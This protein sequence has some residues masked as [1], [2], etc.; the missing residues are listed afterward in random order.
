MDSYWLAMLEGRVRY[1][2]VDGIS[3]RL[4]EAGDPS[5][6]QA[7]VCLHGSGG[8]AEN[9][10]TNVVPLSEAGYVLAPDLLGHGLS[11][12][13][14]DREYTF[15]NLI[16]Q[17][18]NLIATL[19]QEDV[20]LVGLSIGGLVAARVAAENPDRVKKLM[21]ICSAGIVPTGASENTLP[22]M[23]A[24]ARR[25]TL[26]DATE[27]SV[28]DRFGRIMHTT[29]ALS[30][31]MVA[32]RLWMNRKPG[33]ADTVVPVLVDYDENR[34]KYDA[35]ECLLKSIQA[36]TLFAWGG[37]NQPG[38]DVAEKAAAIMPAASVVVFENSKH[39]PHVE[40]HEKFTRE[41]VTFLS[42]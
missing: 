35:D 8:H 9:F 4:L 34:S 20:A 29:D 14:N 32:L 36:E 17:V 11:S 40:E 25:K 39:W 22:R 41:A 6:K 16:A 24:E 38:P 5:S 37:H 42:K 33:V 15:G 30:N 21:L 19:D 2:D 1:A 31:E 27:Q 28:R 10:V 12:R 3:T 26:A 23:D 7:I 13:P 18:S